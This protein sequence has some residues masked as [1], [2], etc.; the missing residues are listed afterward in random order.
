L[1]KG[2]KNLTG[3]GKNK[4]NRSWWQLGHWKGGV[5]GGRLKGAKNPASWND[6]IVTGGSFR[7]PKRSKGVDGEGMGG[8]VIR[9]RGERKKLDANSSLEMSSKNEKP[10]PEGSDQGS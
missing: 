9:G 8:G 1:F 10:P 4:A 7:F 5:G 2:E 3:G 6:W